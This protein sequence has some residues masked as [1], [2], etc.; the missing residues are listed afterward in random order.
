M[1]QFDKDG[2]VVGVDEVGRGSLAGPVAACAF[3]LNRNNISSGID[4]SKKLSKKTRDLLYNEL[5]AST[6]GHIFAI[7]MASNIEIDEINIL[8]ATMLAMKRA[9]NNLSVPFNKVIID[10][11]RVPD[12]LQNASCIIDGDAKY[13]EIAAASI[14]AKVYRDNLMANL[15]E[16]DQYG[17]AQHAGYGTK[18]HIDAI[19]KYGASKIHRRSFLKN[20]L[21]D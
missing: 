6:N 16:S 13:I 11:N 3:I 8:N 18:A 10:G 15:I 7:G 21:R 2:I 14:I 4:D 20:I 5:T 9:V 19:K 1:Q 17:F 12:D